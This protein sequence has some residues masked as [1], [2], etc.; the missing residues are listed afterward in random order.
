MR[1]A[2][3]L[4]MGL[5]DLIIGF[6]VKWLER[7]WVISKFYASWI[8]YQKSEAYKKRLVI[9]GF[10]FAFE[11]FLNSKWERDFYWIR[12]V[13]EEPMLRWQLTLAPWSI[14]VPDLLDTA[15]RSGF[16]KN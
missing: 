12:R 13:A 9:L 8:Q 6:Y 5:V 11:T 2:K 4:L 16:F 10:E 7:H 15:A 3:K 1:K 14:P